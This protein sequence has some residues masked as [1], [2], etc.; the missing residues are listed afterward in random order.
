MLIKVRKWGN[1]LGVRIPK[2]IVNEAQLKDG[3]RIEIT[4]AEDVITL[5]VIDKRKYDLNTLLEGIDK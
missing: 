5:R 2:S 4:S 1:S 3:S